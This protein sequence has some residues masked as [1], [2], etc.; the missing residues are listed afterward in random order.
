LEI[1]NENDEFKK[2]EKIYEILNTYNIK[3]KEQINDEERQD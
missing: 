2:S 1:I 3:F